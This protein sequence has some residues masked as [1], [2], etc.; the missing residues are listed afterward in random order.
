[1]HVLNLNSPI[2]VDHGGVREKAAAGHPGRQSERYHCPPDDFSRPKQIDVLVDLIERDRLDR[3]A[4]LPLRSKG[5]DLAQGFNAKVDPVTGVMTNIRLTG[6][7]SGPAANEA[8]WK[9]T[10]QMYPGTV[11]TVIAKYD[12]PGTYVWHCHILEHEEHD[13]MQWL[14]VLPPQAQP[15]IALPAPPAA[16]TAGTSADAVDTAV[17][18]DGPA[19]GTLADRTAGN[20]SSLRCRVTGANIRRYRDGKPSL[21]R[22]R[23]ACQL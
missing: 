11:T 23:E 20:Y 4:D 8:G 15:M 17:R 5:H 2:A 22:A 1:M 19:P 3:V 13:M 6:Q 7:P 18:R 16:G 21:E 14:T 12:L 10:A 9:D